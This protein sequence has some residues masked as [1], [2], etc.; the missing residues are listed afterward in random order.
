MAKNFYIYCMGEFV[1]FT[2]FADFESGDGEFTLF[3]ANNTFVFCI[4]IFCLLY[5]IDKS[6]LV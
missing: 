4:Y 3:F 6:I 5:F 1:G 2:E